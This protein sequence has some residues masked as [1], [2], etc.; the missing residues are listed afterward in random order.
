MVW[1][2]AQLFDSL[3]G[4]YL[5]FKGGTSLS[6]AYRAI[7]RFSEDIDVTYDIRAIAPDLVDVASDNPVP[8]SRS[9]HAGR[10]V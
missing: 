6:K 8:P 1:A 3:F 9:R 7:Q 5:V 10:G 4:E 2:L